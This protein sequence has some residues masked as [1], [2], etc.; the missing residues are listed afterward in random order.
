M[1]RLT[2]AERWRAIGML[3]TGSTQVQTANIMN[4]SQSVV[5]RL[6]ARYQRSGVV[7]DMQRS[8][9]PRSTSRRDD[10]LVVNQALLNRSLTST[11]LQQYLRRVRGVTVSRQTIRNRDN[12]LAPYV[13]PFAQRHGPRFIFQDDNA[14]AHRARVVTDYLQR[15]NIRTLPWLAMSPDLSPIE[16]VWDILGKRVRRCTPQPRTLG[17]LGA[18]LQEEWGRIPQITI[19]RLIGSMRRRYIACYDNR[20]GPTRY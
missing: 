14:R 12:V 4:I 6:R 17:E 10:R 7:A 5:S 9:R 1:R 8:G 18:A 3:Q 11:I 13:I 20:G 15:R 16:H 2:E 19:R